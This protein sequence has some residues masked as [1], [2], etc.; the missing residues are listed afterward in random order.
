LSSRLLFVKRHCTK[1]LAPTPHLL[2]TLSLAGIVVEGSHSHQGT[3]AL[4]GDGPQF[5]QLG[6]QRASEHRSHAGHAPQERLVV[7]EGAAR[8]DRLVEI[9]IGAL[10]LLLEPAD[11][12][13]D[14]PGDRLWGDLG[15]V[16]LGDTSIAESWR[17]LASIACK[18]R[19]SSSGRTLALGPAASAKG[20]RICASIRSVLARRPVALA[21]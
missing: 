21:N 10:D 3:Q 15:A 13:S 12:G 16:T 14:A 19:A 2:L 11:L 1:V 6:K 20:A 7:R 4:V 8:L 17:L 18:A 9:S 5:G